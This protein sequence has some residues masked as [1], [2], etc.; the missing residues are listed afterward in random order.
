MGL[1][2]RRRA[3]GTG[4]QLAAPAAVAELRADRRPPWGE[5]PCPLTSRGHRLGCGQPP[6]ARRASV[7]A[8]VSGQ[9]GHFEIDDLFSG[10]LQK[11]GRGE[12]GREGRERPG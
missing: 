6:A 5:E 4:S 11:E 8:I 10:W 1:K 12:R 2:P 7:L 9:Q 3:A